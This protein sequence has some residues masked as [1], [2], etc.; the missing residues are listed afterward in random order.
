MVQQNHKVIDLLTALQAGVCKLIGETV[1]LTFWR[2]QVTGSITMDLHNLTELQKYIENHTPGAIPQ[3]EP[4]AW[5]L[6]CGWRFWLLR[7][8]IV[9]GAVLFTLFLSCG[10]IIPILKQFVTQSFHL[11][12]VQYTTLT[13]CDILAP[14]CAVANQN[15]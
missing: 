9:L 8:G 1:E 7:I 14:N 6:Q 5:L 11:K 3:W 13:P 4:L 10:C 12:M 15:A 2:N